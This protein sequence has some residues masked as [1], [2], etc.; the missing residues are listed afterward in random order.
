M[1][2]RSVAP[3]AAA[4]ETDSGVLPRI[5]NVQGRRIRAGSIE[6]LGFLQFSGQSGMGTA[7]QVRTAGKKLCHLLPI[8]S[9][10]ATAMETISS[11]PT[12]RFEL[13]AEVWEARHSLWVYSPTL[14]DVERCGPLLS[15]NDKT[16]SVEKSLWLSDNRVQLMIRKFPGSHFPDQLRVE[17]DCVTRTAVIQATSTVAEKHI[18]FADLETS[19]NQAL[20]W[21]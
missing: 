13:R 11:S 2:N 21:G 15:F 9:T 19:L 5:R 6:W 16:W 18:S 10:T 20:T 14:W 12:K 1:E 4:L 3:R 17:L 7:N 8:R